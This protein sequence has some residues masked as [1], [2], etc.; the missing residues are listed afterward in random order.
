M[1]DGTR[2]AGAASKGKTAAQKQR[3]SG[4]PS[5]GN[6]YSNLRPG[7]KEAWQLAFDE[8]LSGKAAPVKPPKEK[9]K[10]GRK[11]KA[12]KPAPEP[13]PA[14]DEAVTVDEP[15][16]TMPADDEEPEF[17]PIGDTED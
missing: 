6:P 4:K 16:E 7:M 11:P 14:S 2:K 17:V 12:A 9:K 10:P 13:E 15:I 5:K 8:E 1:S 3:E